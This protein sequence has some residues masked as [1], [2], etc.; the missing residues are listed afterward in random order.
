M[1][2]FINTAVNMVSYLIHKYLHQIKTFV[3]KDQVSSSLGKMS[4]FVLCL[5]LMMVKYN[6]RV[7][8]CHPLDVWLKKKSWKCTEA[9]ISLH[10][11][12]WSVCVGVP[13]L[14]SQSWT[15]RSGRRRVK[16][17]QGK[18]IL[19]NIPNWDNLM[20]WQ[21]ERNKCV[22]SKLVGVRNADFKLTHS[23]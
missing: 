23:F 16:T 8:S 4:N 20:C 13:H 11:L 7:R 19:S 14:L 5:L 21:M 17:Y 9:H 12:N 10:I 1:C 3:L 2:W 22:C 18:S 6:L 15:V